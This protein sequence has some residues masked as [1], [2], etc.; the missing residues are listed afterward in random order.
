[1]VYK[2]NDSIS[3]FENIPIDQ[4]VLNKAILFV[5]EFST[6]NSN[7]INLNKKISYLLRM[8]LKLIEV[9]T[10]ETT[11]SP[12]ELLLLIAFQQFPYQENELNQVARSICL[13]FDLWS[14]VKEASHLD[15]LEEIKEVIGVSYKNALFLTY[16][17][18]GSDKSFFYE[19]NNE[20]TDKFNNDLSADLDYDSH[21]KFIHWCGRGYN[22]LLEN[23]EFVHPIVKYP[24]TITNSNPFKGRVIN[25]VTNRTGLFHKLTNNL[26]YPLIDKF[27]TGS[28]NNKF[29]VAFGYVFEKYVGRLLDYH[30]KT[31]DV[32]PEI[33]YKPSKSEVQSIDWFILKGD[34]LIIIEV[35]QSSVFL[36]TK[37]SGSL[38]QLYNDLEKTLIKAIEQIDR[39]ANEVTTQK[40]IEFNVFKEVKYIQGLIVVYD[41]FFQANSIGKD[42]IAKSYTA[43]TPYQIISISDLEDFL[44]LQIDSENMFDV[45]NLKSADDNYNKTDF[46]EFLLSTYP[47]P[48]QL[49]FL[50]D[51]HDDFF[52]VT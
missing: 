45:L 49:K 8:C 1:M 13:F 28:R 19:F 51:I 42:I 23:N 17:I 18:I 27:N 39:T 46:K 43:N 38:T 33:T 37:S 21:S 2:N 30:F 11:Y 41:P 50:K 24:I 15:I 12:N 10:L 26:Y 22:Q 47:K 16:L 34:Q 9:E 32:L 7:I 35:K 4:N 31:W 3:T 40:H 29:K 6:E 36:K 14:T 5:I 52:K 20:G 25:L 48:I 44:A